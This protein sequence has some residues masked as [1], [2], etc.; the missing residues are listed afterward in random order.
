MK[1]MILAGNWKLHKSPVEARR[2]LKDFLP[3]WV[4]YS[5]KHEVWLFPPALSMGA[6]TE[7]CASATNIRFGLQNFWSESQ[8]AFTGE[9]SLEVAKGLGASVALVG[10]SERR[11]IFGEDVSLIREKV[12]LARSLGVLPV[13]CVGETLQEREKGKSLQ[14]VQDQVDSALGELDPF[15]LAVAYE[16]VWAIGTGQVASPEQAGE[17]HAFLR[18]HLSSLW[19]EASESVPLLYGGSVKPENAKDLF[20][21]EAIG[22]FLVGG[23]SLDPSVFLDI[24]KKGR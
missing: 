22:G 19:G 4:P 23:S 9:N 24:L 13:L 3:E 17:V 7:L 20:A 1:K 5:E 12:L 18:Q 6:F 15:E 16:P 21:Q 14:V 2:F 8:G 10:H 11:Q